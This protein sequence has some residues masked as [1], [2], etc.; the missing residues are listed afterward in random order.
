MK[1]YAVSALILA[2]TACGPADKP[3]EK[4]AELAQSSVAMDKENAEKEALAKRAAVFE[5][6]RQN[7]RSKTA[8]YRKLLASRDFWQASNA[9]RECAEVM[10][11]TK[12]RKLVS[13]A[14]IKSWIHD[15]ESPYTLEAYRIRAI[16]ALQ[17]DYPD[18]AKKYEALYAKLSAVAESERQSREAANLHA[19]TATTSDRRSDKDAIEYCWEEQKRKSLDP[20]SA[21]FVAS[22]CEFMELQY[23]QKYGRA[24]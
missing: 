22:T 3:P 2:L 6:C 8:E 23:K 10:E 15:I 20:G 21:R 14:E 11:D 12:L 19:A 13:D 4:K 7:L 17:R 5:D 16:E 24:P 9:I 18:H 1:R